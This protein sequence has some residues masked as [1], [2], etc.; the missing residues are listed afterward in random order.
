MVHQAVPMGRGKTLHP[1]RGNGHPAEDDHGAFS[2]V[3][4]IEKRVID[5]VHASSS[6]LARM[7]EFSFLLMFHQIWII[8][9]FCQQEKDVLTIPLFKPGEKSNIFH[10]GTT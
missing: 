9:L 4:G 5:S 1:F 8:C 2:L 10:A 6:P 3:P 7:H